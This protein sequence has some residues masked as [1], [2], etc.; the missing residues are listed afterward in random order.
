MEN[1][2]PLRQQKPPT[3][4]R[5]FRRQRE[6]RVASAPEM[7]LTNVLESAYGVTIREALQASASPRAV[8]SRRR[9]TGVRTSPATAES[10]HTDTDCRPSTP[11]RLPK[12]PPQRRGATKS[13]DT[14][15]P[16]RPL[17]LRRA[18]SR[19][20]QATRGRA[21]PARKP[22]V[23][24]QPQQASATEQESLALALASVQNS[25]YAQPLALTTPKARPRSA[26]RR[27]GKAGARA[28]AQSP[29]PDIHGDAGGAGSASGHSL[30]GQVDTPLKVDPISGGGAEKRARD[31][32]QAALMPAFR[33]SRPTEAPGMGDRPRRNSGQTSG[34]DTI[35]DGMTTPS[36]VA[37]AAWTEPVASSAFEHETTG[38]TSIKPTENPRTANPGSSLRHHR[39]QTGDRGD[40]HG[41]VTTSLPTVGEE[42]S[43]FVLLCVVGRAFCLLRAMEK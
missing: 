2:T 37:G 12:S 22:P 1:G 3:P 30:L 39:I 11:P 20:R 9:E 7:S 41:A 25:P 40:L 29:R 17:R 28:S 15:P 5:S 8:R 14:R 31:D 27:G 35:F 38:T 23:P 21:V 6:I 19:R 26:R 13:N 24:R 16:K 33:S 34:N 43:G 4:R 10:D 36:S 32:A 42:S 18:R